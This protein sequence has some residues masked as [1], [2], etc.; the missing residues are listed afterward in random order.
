MNRDGFAG[1]AYCHI[2]GPHTE[3][4]HGLV[5]LRKTVEIYDAEIHEALGVMKAALSHSISKDD[6]NLIVY[7][8][9]EEVALR[10]HTD[11]ETST[12]SKQIVEF[13]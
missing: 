2:R 10:L 13:Q 3:F 6:T 1:D 4:S 7:P 9:S 11:I 12:S 8:E 5:P